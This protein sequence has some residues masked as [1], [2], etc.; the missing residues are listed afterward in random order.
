MTIIRS[1]FLMFL[2][3]AAR[4][5]RK[6]QETPVLLRC[7]S[8][9]GP[10]NTTPTRWLRQTVVLDFKKC[11]D[12]LKTKAIRQGGFADTEIWLKIVFGNYV[13]RLTK[14][15]FKTFSLFLFLK[16]IHVQR[17]NSVCFALNFV[18][19]SNS[20]LKSKA[21]SL[22]FHRQPLNVHISTH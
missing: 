15:N 19:T 7:G 1:V 20:L 9:T 6:Q 18:G 14:C 22:T 2:K 17:N 13:M 5:S 12:E 10:D 8:S 11:F 4:A 21:E 3:V 16:K